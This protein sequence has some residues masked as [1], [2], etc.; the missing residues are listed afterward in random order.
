MIPAKLLDSA[1]LARAQT[2]YIY[3]TTKVAMIGKHKYFILV[4]F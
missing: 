2:L 4:N 3:E 1:D